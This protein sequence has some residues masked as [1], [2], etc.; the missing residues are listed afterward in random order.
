M[1][2]TDFKTVLHVTAEGV[3]T[4]DIWEA[5]EKFEQS[6]AVEI[7]K[8]NEEQRIDDYMRA[9]TGSGV[10]FKRKGRIKKRSAIK[11]K[12]EKRRMELYEQG[13]SDR[14]IA[15]ITG[16]CEV[17]IANW[18]GRNGILPNHRTKVG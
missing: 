14:E 11:E 3:V 18:R 9:H 2:A 13:L 7:L 8:R 1:S 4:G 17:T 10:P 12:E 16:R 15:K 6:R 5:L